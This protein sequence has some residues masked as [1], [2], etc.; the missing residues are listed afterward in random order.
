MCDREAIV[1]QQQAEL[2]AAAEEYAKKMGEAEARQQGVEALRSAIKE[3]IE[4]K[5]DIDPIGAGLGYGA[6]LPPV[7]HCSSCQLRPPHF[8]VV[9]QTCASVLCAGQFS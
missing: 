9:S 8:F 5:P 3:G 6:P 1:S 7:A 2:R 4:D